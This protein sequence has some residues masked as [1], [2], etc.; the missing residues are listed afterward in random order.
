MR[1]RMVGFTLQDGK[2][3]SLKAVLADISV[4]LVRVGQ[5][6]RTGNLIFKN[7][8]LGPMRYFSSCLRVR[9]IRLHDVII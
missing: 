3:K 7:Y 2:F 9:L 1:N 4:C 6:G 5:P 8:F